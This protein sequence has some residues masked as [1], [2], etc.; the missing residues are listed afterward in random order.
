[1]GES[2][3]LPS[4]QGCAAEIEPRAC[5]LGA[6]H[7]R[8]I[9]ETVHGADRERAPRWHG[10][11][12][13]TTRTDLR[14]FV[15]PPG[16]SAGA[17]QGRR[18]APLRFLA[19][20][21]L[22]SWA[23]PLRFIPGDP[24]GPHP[25]APAPAQ[26]SDICNAATPRRSPAAPSLLSPSSTQGVGRPGV[27]GLLSCGHSVWGYFPIGADVNTVTT[28][29]HGQAFVDRSFHFSRVSPLG[30]KSWGPPVSVCPSC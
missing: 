9:T 27:V 3:S 29:S 12:V 26:P 1:M 22:V 23:S 5:G 24:C 14:A 19:L 30:A 2:R 21:W 25:C 6:P 17:P 16:W 4:S 7:A 13:N 15:W 28:N 10:T 11:D 20:R 8:Y 18:A